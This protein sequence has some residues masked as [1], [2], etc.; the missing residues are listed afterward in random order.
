MAAAVAEE[1]PPDA[2]DRGALLDRGLEVVGHPHGQLGDAESPAEL[3]QGVEPGPRVVARRRDR[4]Q[5][6]DG[7]PEPGQLVAERRGGVGRATTLLGL[8]GEV[9]LDQDGRPRR[10]AGEHGS[11]LRAVDGLPA[12]DPRGERAHLVA[13]ER[14]EEVPPR[15]RS[16]A[17]EL[18]GLGQQ[19]LGPVLPQVDEPGRERGVEARGGNGLRRRH[20]ADAT[21]IPPRPS[22]GGG[23]AGAHRFDVGG[24]GRGVARRVGGG[25]RGHGSI[26]ARSRRPA[27]GAPSGR[28]GGGRSGRGTPR[29]R[30]RRRRGR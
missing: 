13:L 28:H 12:H 23:D 7:Q 1:G 22:G 9:D 26:T 8:A 11:E 16:V 30:R 17:R 5:A 15:G 4:H 14:T 21:G 6:G 10:V 27:P 25:R 29:C 20:E 2:H 3:P 18:G 19:L 24:D